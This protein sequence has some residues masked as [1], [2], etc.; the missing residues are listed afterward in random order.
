MRAEILSIGTEILLGQIVD[1]NAPYLARHLADLGI[2]LFFISQVG[3]NQARVTETLQRAW[4]RADLIVT[5]GGLGPTEDDVTR[6][7]IAALLGET[8][9]VNLEIEQTLR[10]FFQGRGLTMPERNLKQAWIIPSA[11]VIQNPVG[12]AP[13]WLVERGGKI[14]V[15]MPGVPREMYRMW[16]REVLPVLV[17]RSGATL[18]T[19]VLRVTGLGESHVE[20]R[21][22]DLIHSTNP[23][24][25]TYA[26]P[27]AVDVR[28]SAKA[29]SAEEGEALIAPVEAQAHKAL[30]PHVFGT[31]SQTLVG[32]VA[33]M[34]QERH[35][36]AAVME[37]CT[38]GQLSAALTQL[39]GSSNHF[40]G[41]LVTYATDAKVAMGVPQET[42]DMY[43][44]ISDEAALAMARA[45]RD[46]LAADV[47]VGVTGVAGPDSQDGHPVGE[48]HLAV[49]SPDGEIARAVR[50][51]GERSEIQRRATLVALDLLRRHL[52]HYPA[53]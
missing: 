29:P 52:L 14:I 47:G 2:D 41:G 9:A 40:R 51:S 39:P 4:D 36:M 26:K 50:L 10:A 53:A 31:G 25:A 28:I 19:H 45:A 6:E 11:T 46:R 15:A 27:E 32:L 13:G 20:E 3:D 42:I 38:G 43:G 37:S 44:V 34:L 8:P 35:W 23:T 5:T 48:I 21:L 22:G 17:G 30:G 49:V 1:T 24:V 7:A 16:E 12:T 18:V 33:E